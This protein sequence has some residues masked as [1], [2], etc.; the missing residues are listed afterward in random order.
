MSVHISLGGG[1]NTVGNDMWGLCLMCDAT[2]PVVSASLGAAW[3]VSRILYTWGYCRRDKE[4]GSGRR[5]GS[6]QSLF[7]FALLGLSGMTG[8]QLLMG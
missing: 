7:E 4:N 3:C 5:I 1:G 8:Y 2:D 6:L